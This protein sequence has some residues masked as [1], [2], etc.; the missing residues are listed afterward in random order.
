MNTNP[1]RSRSLYRKQ[2]EQKRNYGTS[3]LAIC[4]LLIVSL[5]N[6][7]AVPNINTYINSTE[8]RSVSTSVK[9][10][11]KRTTRNDELVI[12]SKAK[13]PFYI[14]ITEIE[15]INNF[16]NQVNVAA[17]K[18]AKEM[19]KDQVN[20]KDISFS[21]NTSTYFDRY[22]YTLKDFGQLVNQYYSGEKVK[23]KKTA[24]VGFILKFISTLIDV[25]SLL[26]LVWYILKKKIIR[27]N[28]G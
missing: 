6:F 23:A 17:I 2:L 1:R 28:D 25:V 13:K 21:K 16:A 12:I 24:F 5:V 27:S 26:M 8:Y 14:E 10:S 7:Q 20:P 4:L 3:V 9:M 15:G 22:G 11:H 18:V 19:H